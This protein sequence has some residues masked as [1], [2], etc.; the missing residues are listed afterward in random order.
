MNS[1]PPRSSRF[2]RREVRMHMPWPTSMWAGKRVLRREA[3]LRYSGAAWSPCLR[4][5]GRCCTSMC[6]AAEK[7]GGQRGCTRPSGR[8]STFS[9]PSS[10]SSRLSATS[11]LPYRSRANSTRNC[12]A[13]G[14]RLHGLSSL[15]ISVSSGSGG[16]SSVGRLSIHGGRDCSTVFW[17][18]SRLDTMIP[19]QK[20]T[21]AL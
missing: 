19:G 12:E 16:G 9:T 10:S 2:R 4:A 3:H 20:R 13:D 8:P 11:G 7:G 1:N 5:R 17:D 21:V 18:S 14:H 6:P 15:M